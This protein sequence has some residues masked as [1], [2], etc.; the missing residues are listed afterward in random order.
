VIDEQLAELM[1]NAYNG[2]EPNPWKTFDGRPVPRW[3]EVTDQVRGK[4]TAAAREA[5]MKLTQ[6]WTGGAR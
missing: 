2:Q 3:S 5:R 1:F 4:W 6:E